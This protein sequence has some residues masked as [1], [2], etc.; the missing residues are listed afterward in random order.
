MSPLAIAVAAATAWSGFVSIYLLLLTAAALAGRDVK[1]PPGP[2]RRRFAILIAARDEEQLIG[3]LLE[4]IRAQ[5]YPADG[6]DVYVVADNCTDRTAERARAAGATVL[7]RFDSR[8]QTKGYA[9]DWLVSQLRRSG[10]RHDAFVILDADSVVCSNLLRSMD[11]HLEAGSQV[12]QVDYGVLNAD[13]SPV[14]ALRSIALAALHLLRP[15]GRARLGLSCGLRGNGM[16]FSAPIVAAFGWRWHSLVE[17]LESHAALVRAGV[18]IDFAPETRVLADMPTT[19]GQA[20]DQNT[21]W[22]RGRLQ[23]AAHWAPRLLLAALQQRSVVALDAA[24]ELVI[25]PLSV[26]LATAFT[27]LVG[28]LVL[29]SRTIVSVS[30]A[31]LAGQAA[32]VLAALALIRAPRKTYLA[33]CRAPAYVAWKFAIYTRALLLPSAVRWSRVRRGADES[34]GG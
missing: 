1:L 33:L 25:P 14:A 11:A 21:R 31:S 34:G 17:D 30:G 29:R 22:E 18:R 16:C 3:R 9:L 15:L 24:I 28:G 10:P 19:F 27:A 20:V 5:D 6:F 32:Y 12:V 26:C 2:A 13:E 23:T 7:E 4:S 8:R